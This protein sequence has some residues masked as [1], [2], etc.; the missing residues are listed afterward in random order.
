MIRLLIS[1]LLIFSSCSNN[2]AKTYSGEGLV[3]FK[4]KGKEVYSAEYSYVIFDRKIY[5]F[6]IDKIYNKKYLTNLSN[7][8]YEKSPFDYTLKDSI[9]NLFL[10]KQLNLK[11]QSAYLYKLGNSNFYEDK[12][13][14][15]FLCFNVK[16]KANLYVEKSNHFNKGNVFGINVS[17]EYIVVLDSLL[18]TNKLNSEQLALY[19]LKKSK[20]LRANVHFISDEMNEMEFGD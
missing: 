7:K 12:F 15:L 13:N 2:K 3:I 20:I 4:L 9:Y 19:K 11:R 1:L 14:N 6:L 17:S 18:E 16:M 5:P 10:T 8:Y